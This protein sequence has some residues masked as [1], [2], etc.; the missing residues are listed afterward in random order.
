MDSRAHLL[1]PLLLIACVSCQGGDEPLPQQSRGI[2]FPISCDSP[3]QKRF[4]HGVYLLHNMMYKQ[5]LDEFKSAAE[6][7][8]E[9]AML[10]WGIAMSLFHPK[11]PGE[12]TENALKMG[13]AA[14]E[15]TRALA[16]RSTDREKGYIEAVGAYYRDWQNK[17]RDARKANWRQAQGKHAAAYPE[18]S[19]AQIFFALAQITTSDP[20]DKTYAQDRNAAKLLEKILEERPE[21]PGVLH[22]LLHAYDNPVYAAW[23]RS[24]AVAYESV[25][26][27]APHALH[28][29]THTYVRLG[30]WEQ[31]ISWNIRSRD[32]AARQP[33]N[34]GKL[35]KHYLHALDYL[36]YG[37]LQVADDVRA[38]SEVAKANA[39]TAWELNSGPGAYAL[40][41]APARLAIERRAWKEAATL[42]ARAVPY[43]W[44]LYPWAE[45]ITYAARG[46]GS[47][48]VGDVETAEQSLLELG[49]LEKLTKDSWWQGRI[50]I[51]RD[52]ISGWVAYHRGETQRARTQLSRAAEQELAAGKQS[53]E[54]GHIVYASE[55]LGEL[56]LELNRPHDAL[57][58][59]RRTLEDSPQRFHALFGAGKAAEM[60]NL[61]K[62]AADHYTMLTTMVVDTNQRPQTQHAA[63]FL[64]KLTP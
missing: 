15:E 60:A 42:Q 12:P 21:H 4:D 23:C 54:P 38:Q 30:D 58:V 29:P 25:A 40:A 2:S 20:Y 36:V 28:M 9:C 52:V 55:Q 61:Q 62:E 32:S 53:V 5:A 19:E 64:A 56:L 46:L 47:V 45:A 7:D 26:P 41:A 51:Q 10:Q 31:V 6:V 17:D 48:R 18:D 39:Q 35:S 22:Y 33:L 27:D 8:P 50:R 59:F 43:T 37:Y 34:D 24:A 11:W 13:A 63:Q 3:T 57:E 49:R 14:V 16:T 44:D 1:G